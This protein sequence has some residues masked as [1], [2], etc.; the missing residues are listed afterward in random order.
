[1]YK[2]LISQLF[3][4]HQCRL[5]PLPVIL[6]NACTI[7]H[8]EISVFGVQFFQSV[9]SVDYVTYVSNH[10]VTAP[11]YTDHFR[12]SDSGTISNLCLSRCSHMCKLPPADPAIANSLKLIQ[13]QQNPQKIFP[14]WGNNLIKSWISPWGGLRFNLILWHIRDLSGWLP[15]PI[16][17]IVLTRKAEFYQLPLNRTSLYYF[18]FLGFYL[19]HF[20]LNQSFKNFCKLKTLPSFILYR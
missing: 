15:V 9:D 13:I 5:A 17:G 1:M 16:K 7:S 2:W 12:L 3:R 4:K 19:R 11:L 10:R 14:S 20:F 8:C 18:Y 6:N